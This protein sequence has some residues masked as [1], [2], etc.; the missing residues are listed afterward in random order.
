MPVLHVKNIGPL[1]DTGVLSIES[2]TLF[3]GK[4]STGKSTLMKV[5]SFCTWVEKQVMLDDEE[6]LSKYSRYHTFYK[7]LNQFYR[8][9]ESY[10]QKDSYIYYKGECVSIELEGMKTNAKIRKNSDFK[11]NRHNT[12]ISFIP[13][14]RNL[15]SAI[16]NVDRVYR[17]KE[18]DLLFNFIFEWDEVRPFYAQNPLK[19]SVADNLEYFYNEKK[20]KDLLRIIDSKKEFSTFFGS[21][22]VQSALPIEA[23]LN[24][25]VSVIGK[26]VDFT[27]QSISNMIMSFLQYEGKRIEELDPKDIKAFQDQLLY[28][29]NIKL[30]IEEPE[31]NL[32]PESQKDLLLDIVRVLNEANAKSDKKSSIVIT[33]HSPYILSVI[34]VLLIA[35]HA[36]SKDKNRANKV[37]D[38]KYILENSNIKAYY[39]SDGVVSDIID[40][41]LNMISGMEL[42][43][44]SDWVEESIIAL[45]NII[46]L[47]E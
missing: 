46:Y 20:E 44:V 42:D 43:S 10:Y 31:Q 21:S 2:L 26:P 3:I 23:M 19:I 27:K 30:F 38:E 4:Q 9:D 41:D 15:I 45:N 39:I 36:F 18:L 5:L 47:Y 7:D 1:K 35:G 34:N 37:I 12:K 17:S 14:E 32:Y 8:L 25:F 28:Y 6:T 13:S 40:N 11:D 16:K 24:Y 22:G 29:K 33:T